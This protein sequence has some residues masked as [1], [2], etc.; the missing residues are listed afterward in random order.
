[1]RFTGKREHVVDFIFTLALFCVFAASSVLVTVIG[2]GVYKSVT[3]HM[4]INNTSRTSLAYIAEKIR[5][6]DMA[7]SVSAQE[8]EGHT[9]LVL[10]EYYD[11]TEYATYIYED[12]G[13]LKELF[14]KASSTPALAAGQPI[15]EVSDFE[16][17]QLKDRLYRF[18]VEDTDGGRFSV[19]V[20]QKSVSK[21]DSADAKGGTDE[22]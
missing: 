17:M 13:Q 21:N 1:M 8:I 16:A 10:S 18:T 5:Q 20:C 19:D 9:A 15:M 12:E 3:S 11:G 14:Q 7:S 4:Q 6:N 2:A 22:K